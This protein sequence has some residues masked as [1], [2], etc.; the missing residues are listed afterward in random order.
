MIN[1]MNNV[2]CVFAETALWCRDESPPFFLWPLRAS[3]L[4]FVRPRWNA[5]HDFGCKIRPFC[6]YTFM[7]QGRKSVF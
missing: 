5:F 6:S 2:K 7:L 3:D 4:A 1:N